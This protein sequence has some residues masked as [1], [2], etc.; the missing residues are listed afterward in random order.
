[1]KKISIIFILTFLSLI[2]LSCSSDDVSSSSNSDKDT[3]EQTEKTIV[4]EKYDNQNI[5]EEN[6]DISDEDTISTKWCSSG[7]VIIPQNGQMFV[8]CDLDNRKKQ[9]MICKNGVWVKQGNCISSMVDIPAGEFRMGCHKSLEG[10]D[11]LCDTD[12]VPEHIV[13]LSDFKI[14]KFEVTVA[15]FN[16][17]IAAGVCK[18]SDSQKMFQ[19]F[20]DNE[21]CNL[22]APGKKDHPMNCVSWK[23]ANTYCKWIGKKLPSEA[24]WEK[25]AKGTQNNVYP[26]GNKP[27]PSCSIAIVKNTTAGC[28]FDSTFPIGSKEN[29]KSYYGVYD[30]AGNVSEFVSD[31]YEKDF[32]NSKEASLKD[33]IGPKDM[34]NEQLKISRGGSFVDREKELRTFYRK[35]CS[36]TDL[37]VNLGFRCVKQ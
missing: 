14:D 29:G 24:Q 34:P 31:W 30:M 35:S 19:I 16:K 18:N 17:C 15:E 13:E 9:K 12:N 1:M 28:D 25:A 22:G 10:N 37:S 21:K 5:N 3:I 11:S 2:F 4:D 32:Y 6:K 27:T 33:V 23:G 8:N 7:D 26:W 20:S 36:L